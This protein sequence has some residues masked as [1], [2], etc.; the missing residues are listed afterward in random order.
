MTRTYD[1]LVRDRI[2]E[3]ID[4]SGE[5]AVTDVVEGAAFD[6]RLREKLVEE[7]REFRDDESEAELADVLCVLET[8]LDRDSIDRDRV[9]RLRR[10]KRTECG[11]FEEGIVLERVE[12]D[13]SP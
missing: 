10:E 13:S 2:P 9:E 3:R 7:A 1:K 4:E 5:T 8:I 6:A 11:G 12:T